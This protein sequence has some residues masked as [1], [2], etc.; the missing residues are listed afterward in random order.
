MPDKKAKSKKSK[1]SKVAPAKRGMKRDKKQVK[2][3]VKTA[4][5]RKGGSPKKEITKT[6]K[7]AV[8]KQD[9]TPLLAKGAIA[10]CI[11][12]TAECEPEDCERIS[13]W[14]RNLVKRDLESCAN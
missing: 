14:I 2:K 7:P 11:G 5:V 3:T 6:L 10:P 8:K 9:Y 13:E 4:H 12:C 1:K